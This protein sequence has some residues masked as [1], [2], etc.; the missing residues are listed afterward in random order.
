MQCLPLTK[1]TMSSFMSKCN[2]VSDVQTLDIF[3]V[4]ATS[5]LSRQLDKQV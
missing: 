5:T 1:D 3:E 2:C 4:V